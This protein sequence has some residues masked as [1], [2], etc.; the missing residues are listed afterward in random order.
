MHVLRLALLAVLVV[1]SL[2]S[3]TRA[4]AQPASGGK[5]YRIAILG[6]EN[7]PPWE[8]FRHGLRDLGYVDGRNVVLDWRWSE[9]KVDRFPALATEVIGLKPDVI[10]ASGTQAVRAAKQA[11]S[12]I[13]IVM[14]VS[15]YPD[16][17]GLVAS[18]AHPGGNVTG[19]SNLGPEL[20]AKKIE[21]LKEMAPA[22]S[23]IAVVWNPGS[24]VETLTFHELAGA[25]RAVGLDVQSAEVRDPDA[26]ETA[27][28]TIASGR[29]NGLI[30]LGNPINFKGRHLIADF[31]VKNRLASMY[32][33]GLFV[34]SGGL[35]SYAPSFTDLFRRAASYVD[36]ILKGA[37]PADLPVEQPTKFE[38][39]INVRTAKSLGITIPPALRLRADRT[40]E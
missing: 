12:T 19:L 13:P 15:S 23:R 38:L 16:K 20:S 3:G 11:T 5:V 14:T 37:S 32:D 2:C 26:F 10:V 40:V 39:V 21:L 35:M 6:N 28:A 24:P 30:A 36:R 33:E 17:L 22:I 29:A 8:G 7:N 9:G 27:F 34:E 25:A 31:A 4:M 18:L 1:A